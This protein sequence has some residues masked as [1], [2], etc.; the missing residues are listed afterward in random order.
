M[1]RV[2]DSVLRL[3]Q[4]IVAG[5]R[6][7]EGQYARARGSVDKRVIH[8]GGKD[9]LL[10]I[11]RLK[12]ESPKKILF[13]FYGNFSRR[14]SPRRLEL[15]AWRRYVSK[16]VLCSVMNRWSLVKLFIDECSRW[17]LKTIL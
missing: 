1:R 12:K 5:T 9:Q 10:K 7:V 16:I 8:S 14:D 2:R 13:H 4:L 6:H 15:K 17:Q 11:I 3:G